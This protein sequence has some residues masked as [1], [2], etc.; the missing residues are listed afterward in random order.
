MFLLQRNKPKAWFSLHLVLLEQM[1]FFGGKDSSPNQFVVILPPKYKFYFIWPSY[2]NEINLSVCSFANAKQDFK[3]LALRKDILWRWYACRTPL[4]RARIIVFLGYFHSG[5]F[6]IISK[7]LSYNIWPIF[8][9]FLY[10]S[11]PYS[12]Q[13]FLHTTFRFIITELL[14]IFSSLNFKNGAWKM[15]KTLRHE[16]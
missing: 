14:T 13:Y 7:V 6:Q 16:H 5:R 2:E 4:W 1:M 3:W 12:G 8:Q 9:H 11:N 10:I 15:G